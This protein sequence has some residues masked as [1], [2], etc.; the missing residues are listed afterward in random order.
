MHKVNVKGILSAKN[1]MNIYRGC[2]HGCIYCDSRSLCYQMNH[3]F[4]DIEVKANAVGL[5]ENTLRRKRNKCMIGTGAM[6]DPYMPI[7]E[8]LGN[9]RKCLE[10]IER[11][12]FGVTMITKSTKVLRDLDLLKKINEKS[13]CVVQMTLTTYDEDLCR[14]VEPNVETTYERF[15]A[16][17]ILHDNG[18]PTVVWLCPI[19]PF[20]ND[21]EENIRGI[22]DYC[23]RAKVKGIINFDMG[24]TLR[25][26]NREYFY[27]KLD[28][29][30]PGLKEKYIRMYGNSYQL[31]SPNSRQLNMIY[32]SECIK[33]GI[34]CDVNECFEYLN[35]YEDK[36]G[37]EQISL[38]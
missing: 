13:K 22:L 8:K 1:G 16:L 4:E 34:M 32:K 14:I 36:Y 7:E 38:I 31:S 5:L 17:E 30:F 3:K 9:M 35:K 25:D 12:G 29:H 18:I 21:T 24:V 27:K 6:S 33:N 23:V 20:I 11:Y 28:E 37:G 2:L 26:G 10:V 19:L 15:R